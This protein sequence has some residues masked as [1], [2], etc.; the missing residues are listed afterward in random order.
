MGLKSDTTPDAL[1]R[2]WL[3]LNEFP[4]TEVSI[5]ACAEVL[6]E[7]AKRERER[8]LAEDLETYAAHILEEQATR[9]CS[10]VEK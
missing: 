10:V 1:E 7:A 9:L 8:G 5:I 2:L 4:A 6:K 3:L